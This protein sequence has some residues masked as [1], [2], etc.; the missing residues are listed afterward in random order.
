M[1]RPKSDKP[2]YC[3]DK[4]T[5][6]AYVTFDGHRKYLGAYGSQASR[7][8]YDR[9]IGE[10]IASGR[11]SAPTRPT[12][13]AAGITVSQVIAAFWRYAAG[14]Y[15]HSREAD[16]FREALRPLHKLYGPTPAAAFGPL[17]LKAVREHCINELD[18]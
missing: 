15:S 3:R 1:P 6:R 8:K 12:D 2:G 9:L 11:V 5:N 13:A 7:D 17:A 4:T 16:N 10:W 14:Y 18:W